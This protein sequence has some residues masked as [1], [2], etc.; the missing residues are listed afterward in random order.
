MSFY[1]G[2]AGS[3]GSVVLQP[4]Q[5]SAYGMPGVQMAPTMQQ[6]PMQMPMQMGVQ[7]AQPMYAA[8]QQHMQMMPMA[9]AAPRPQAYY[10]PAPAMVPMAP[11]GY[12][13]HRPQVAYGYPGMQMGYYPGPPTVVVSSSR[14]GHKRRSSRH[15]GFLGYL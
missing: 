7:M 2:S 9:V 5:G 1:A 11:M 10:Q 4:T 14:S 12:P 15:G 13:A 6:V 8:P 3:V